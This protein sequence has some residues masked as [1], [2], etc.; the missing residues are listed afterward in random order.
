MQERIVGVS[1]KLPPC[2]LSRKLAEFFCLHSAA[3]RLSK[4]LLEVDGTETSTA[5]IM[6]TRMIGSMSDCPS[7]L[8]IKKC[9]TIV[10]QQLNLLQ[11][12]TQNSCVVQCMKAPT[13]QATAA[14]PGCYLYISPH[15]ISDSVF[16]TTHITGCK[17]NESL[18]TI[19]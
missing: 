8:L 10:T 19:I 18:Q 13:Q 4:S 12:S 17:E 14:T 2:I 16:L 11:H 1:R 3:S 7:I 5:D 6:H 9:W 15:N